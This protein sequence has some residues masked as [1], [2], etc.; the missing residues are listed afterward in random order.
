MQ[1]GN[2]SISVSDNTLN[3]IAKAI[4]APV[5]S[6]LGAINGTFGKIPRFELT[7]KVK[8]EATQNGL[9]HFVKDDTV[10]DAIIDSG[11]LRPSDNMTSYGRKTCFMFCGGP[12]VDNYAKNLTDSSLVEKDNLWKRQINPYITPTR[13]ATAIRFTPQM[14]DLANYSFRGLEDGAF[15]YE[16]YCILPKDTVEK[17]KMVP[18]LVRDSSGFPIKDKNGEYQVA[19]REALPEELSEDKTTYMAK[20]DYLQYMM[21]KGIEYG[22][23]RADGSPKTKIETKIKAMTDPSRMEFDLS[24]ENATKNFQDMVASLKDRV[25]SMFQSR[26]SMEKS[27]EECLQDFNFK[28]KNPYRDKKFALAVASLQSK[29][30]LSQLDLNDVLSDFT[31]SQAGEF[32]SK[33]YGQLE[34]VITRA[35]IHGKSHTD[36]VAL[37]AMMIAHNEGIFENDEDNRIKDI[38]AT[39][40]MYHD[41]GRVL[42]QGP[43]AGRGARKIAKMDL[44][45]ADGKPYS[46]E[47]KKMV[48]ALVEA[49]EGKPNKI[50]K[51]IKKYQIQ[52]T[53]NIDLLKRLNSVVRDADAL[54]R[55]RIDSNGLL[56]YKVNLNP[57]YL[58]ND[59]S[60]MLINAAYQLEFLTKRVPNI[61]NVLNF[62]RPESTATYRMQES[63]RDFD[64]RIR[65]DN[66]PTLDKR[67]L[68]DNSEDRQNHKAQDE[69]DQDRTL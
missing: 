19:F 58:V 61:N 9:Y 60:K 49:H 29:D 23:L 34:S 37:Q 6:I 11:Y 30:G 53:A 59:T 26:T 4:G 32:F 15:M 47:D 43:H 35:G 56:G 46:D 7:E 50:D 25:K 62:G 36:R 8:E 5:K 52:D 54:D 14:K 18:D 20:P 64:D 55:V 51:M 17:V 69:V 12:S 27:A 2:L 41:I 28:R 1:L 40:A 3:K 67:I 16:G 66:I 42:D 68:K 45:Y 21:E 63:A 44:R 22:Y 13:V 39:A 10:A 31:H 57:E 33:K 65:V 24:A 48:M 38:L